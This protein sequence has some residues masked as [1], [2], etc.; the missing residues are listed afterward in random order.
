MDFILTAIALS[1]WIVSQEILLWLL[2]TGDS[3]KCHCPY[4]CKDVRSERKGTPDKPNFYDRSDS[5]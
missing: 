1:I 3:D 2:L 5:V 4:G